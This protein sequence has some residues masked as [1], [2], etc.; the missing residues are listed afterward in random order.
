[1]TV[2]HKCF[3][4]RKCPFF[5]GSDILPDCSQSFS[6][7]GES[8]SDIT[9]PSNSD[10][11]VGPELD[12]ITENATTSG[13]ETFDSSTDDDSDE[14]VDSDGVNNVQQN[15]GPSLLVLP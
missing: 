1:M 9:D 3:R 14:D 8:S 11:S 10:S 5:D 7:G 2:F 12:F 13:V 6:I 15:C 4:K